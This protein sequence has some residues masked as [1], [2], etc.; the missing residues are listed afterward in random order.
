[1]NTAMWYKLGYMSDLTIQLSSKQVNQLKNGI[2]LTIQII[3][4]SVSPS[5][6]ALSWNEIVAN[7]NKE[8]IVICLAKFQCLSRQMVIIM[9]KI[10]QLLK[11]MYVYRQRFPWLGFL[12]LLSVFF[13]MKVS[14][15]SQSSRKLGLSINTYLNSST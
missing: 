12:V 15:L 4:F 11:S 9:T 5:L 8:T 10:E 6:G 7:T 1:M 3:V 2:L 13:L 14:V